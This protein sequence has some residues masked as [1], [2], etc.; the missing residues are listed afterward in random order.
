MSA[1]IGDLGLLSDMH[2]AA[3]VDRGGSIEW[4][5][6]PHFS[7]PSV[8]GRILDPRAGHFRVAPALIESVERRYLDDSLVLRTTFRTRTG[9][10]ELTDAL[11][12]A[13]GVRGHDL[14]RGSPHL[15]LR[16]AR[17]TS[18]DI[19]LEVDFVPRFE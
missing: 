18:G 19:D 1:R 5:C 17:C 13:P 11:A 7:S 6:L 12:M 16:H 14:G 9:T 15:I 8:F 3:L 4:W 10:L 2:S